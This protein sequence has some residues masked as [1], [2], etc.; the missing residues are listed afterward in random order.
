MKAIIV[1][2]KMV[3]GSFAS[4][5]LAR[6]Q[7]TLYVMHVKLCKDEANGETDSD[8]EPWHKWLGQMR[9]L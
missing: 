6:K 9:E 8:S 4:E 5:V 3:C 7:G 1:A 2:F